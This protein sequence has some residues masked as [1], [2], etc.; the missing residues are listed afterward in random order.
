MPR[1]GVFIQSRQWEQK[2]TDLRLPSASRPE[3]PRQLRA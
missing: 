1:R 3:A 2:F